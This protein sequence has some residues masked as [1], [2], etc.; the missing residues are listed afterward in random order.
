MRDYMFSK[1]IKE[2]SALIIL[3]FIIDIIP[4][5]VIAADKITEDEGTK[6][7]DYYFFI[8]IE[9]SRLGK[10]KEAVDAFKQAIRID[11]DD[12]LA[13][14]NLGLSYKH[15]SNYQ[16][17][18]EAFKQSLRIKKEDADT[19]YMIGLAMDQY[20]ILKSLDNELANKLFNLIYP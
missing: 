16:D 3:I 8:G 12:Y 13:Y 7:A 14:F 4:C 2:I 17:A 6:D 5:I 20:T 11:S 1:F 18:L 9:H 15:L 19:H 10:V